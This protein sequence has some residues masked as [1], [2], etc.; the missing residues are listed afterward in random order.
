MRALL[1]LFAVT[2]VT[3]GC[4][5][6]RYYD[7]YDRSYGSYGRSYEPYDRNYDR[8]PY[9]RAPEPYGRRGAQQPL[10]I[11]DAPGGK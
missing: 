9:G 6:D 1:L 7:P 2:L 3:A 4:V 10:Q 5:P 11:P 8:N